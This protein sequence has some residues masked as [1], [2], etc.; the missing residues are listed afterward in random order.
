MQKYEL[1]F[2]ITRN[3]VKKWQNP[4][5]NNKPKICISQKKVVPSQA[6]SI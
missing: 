6:D 3:K 4:E 1:F 5:D 2:E